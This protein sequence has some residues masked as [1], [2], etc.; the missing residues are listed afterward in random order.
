[1]VSV[2]VAWRGGKVPA[3]QPG[4]VRNF[5]FYPVLSCV[6]S[7]S[8][9]AIKLSTHSGSPAIV[10]L[11]SVLVHCLLH[12]YVRRGGVYRFTQIWKVGEN[13]GNENLTGKV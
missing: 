4:G 11:S 7:V 5:S 8:G 2:A 9:P 6:V 12:L 1:M 3:F 10:F 13:Q